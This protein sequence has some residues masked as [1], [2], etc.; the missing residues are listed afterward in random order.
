MVAEPTLSNAAVP[1][2]GAGNGALAD[3]RGPRRYPPRRN[4]PTKLGPM[5]AIDRRNVSGIHI[6]TTRTAAGLLLEPKVTLEVGDGRLLRVR[7]LG[8]TIEYRA[9]APNADRSAGLSAPSRRARSAR[10]R[11]RL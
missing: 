2:G 7:N 10:A 4:R 11:P 6:S 3:R 8:A 1:A 9:A 5:S